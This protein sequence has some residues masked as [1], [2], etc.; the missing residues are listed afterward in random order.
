ML[1]S[2]HTEKPFN[3]TLSNPIKVLVSPPAT[4]KAHLIWHFGRHN[5]DILLLN[6]LLR[7]ILLLKLCPESLAIINPS[8]SDTK[9]PF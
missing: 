4:V 1:F 5:I 3:L 2:N 8:S 6:W 9:K 7:T